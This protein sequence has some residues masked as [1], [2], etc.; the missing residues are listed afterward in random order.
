VQRPVAADIALP[1][2]SCS[3]WGHPSLFAA[4]LVSAA[5]QK[6]LDGLEDE[7]DSGNANLKR[8]TER[9]KLVTRDARTCWLYAV[10]CILLGVLVLL[11]ALRWW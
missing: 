10:I 4:C 7:V 2:F 6:L 11:V 3:N 1:V 8:E 5:P 9:T